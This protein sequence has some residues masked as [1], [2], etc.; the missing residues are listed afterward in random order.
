[1]NRPS[2]QAHKHKDLGLRTFT[3]EVSILLLLGGE[4]RDRLNQSAHAWQ[5]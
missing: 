5:G 1:M 4:R 3:E 2:G